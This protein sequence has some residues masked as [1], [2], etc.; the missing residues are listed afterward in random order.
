MLPNPASLL[1]AEHWSTGGCGTP[2]ASLVEEEAVTFQ[3]GI[4]RTSRGES[5]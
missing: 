1:L 5:C 2:S 4:F 3:L